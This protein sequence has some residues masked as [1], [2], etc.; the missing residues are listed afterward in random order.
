MGNK[1]RTYLAG[2]PYGLQGVITSLSA[3]EYIVKIAHEVGPM[4][5]GSEYSP[6]Y[7]TPDQYLVITEVVD[8]D[9]QF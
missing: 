8:V 4:T 3:D 5:G 2:G 1:Y 6:A 7:K 9:G